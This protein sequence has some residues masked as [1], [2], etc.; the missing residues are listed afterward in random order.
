M[1]CA[2]PIRTCTRKPVQVR[3]DHGTRPP[4][5]GSCAPPPARPLPSRSGS[6][7]TWR[8]VGRGSTP[9]QRGSG[10]SQDRERK[11]DRKR[12]P[13]SPFA[14]SCPAPAPGFGA[15]GRDASEDVLERGSGRRSH[16]GSGRAPSRSRALSGQTTSDGAM[17]RS[18]SY[19]WLLP[20]TRATYVGLHRRKRSNDSSRSLHAAEKPTLRRSSLFRPSG[21]RCRD[22]EMQRCGDGDDTQRSCA[23]PNGRAERGRERFF[24]GRRVEASRVESRWSR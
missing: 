19:K 7:V 17:L 10:T 16:R 15:R 11:R 6:P 12:S 18:D 20:R 13:P 21:Q 5:R 3:G 22:A 23:R 2:L 24:P 14:A 9:C 1:G 8:R 4:L